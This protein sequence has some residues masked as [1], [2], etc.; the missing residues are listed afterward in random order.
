MLKSLLVC[1]KYSVIILLD[2]ILVFQISAFT[3]DKLHQED[4]I[5]YMQLNIHLLNAKEG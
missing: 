1:V 5:P 3:A 2:R 4:L